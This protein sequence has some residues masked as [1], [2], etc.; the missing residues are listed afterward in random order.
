MVSQVGD[1]PDKVT[2]G[3]THCEPYLRRTFKDDGRNEGGRPRRPRRQA[4]A[5][6]PQRQGTARPRPGIATGQ[7]EDGR[8]AAVAVIPT[9]VLVGPLGAVG[10]HLR[11]RRAGRLLRR[12]MVLLWVA[13]TASTVW[14]VHAWFRGD[15]RTWLGTPQLLWVCLAVLALAGVGGMGIRYRRAAAHGSG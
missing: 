5:A 14:F 10:V 6:G 4:A 9:F 11:S 12:W 2:W 8:R 7:A 13:C 15:L 1:E 3:F